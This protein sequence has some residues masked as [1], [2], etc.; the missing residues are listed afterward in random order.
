MNLILSVVAGDNGSLTDRVCIADVQEFRFIILLMRADR[1]RSAET[2][3]SN[4]D[5]EINPD[6]QSYR[7][8]RLYF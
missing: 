6:F 5:E 1:T 2:V 8:D 4:H 3:K 7:A